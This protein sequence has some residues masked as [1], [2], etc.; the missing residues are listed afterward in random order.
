MVDKKVWNLH[1]TG[2]LSEAVDR[3]L[4]GMFQEEEASRLL[5]I[6]L[7]CVQA[8]AELRPAMSTV[9][10]MLTDSHEISQPTQPPFLNSSIAEIHQYIP[11]KTYSFEPGSQS[12]S[13]GNNMTESEI[14]P[15]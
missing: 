14:V 4:E 9:V 15:R 3:D 13:S 5:K 8:S 6:G 1:G 12:H 2:R 10:K 7:L 11:P